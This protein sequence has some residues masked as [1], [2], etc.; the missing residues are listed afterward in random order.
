MDNEVL[1]MTISEFGRRPYENGS[2]GTDHGAASP[3][4]LFGPALQGSGFIGQHPELTEWDADDNLIPTNDFRDVY[5]SVLTNWFCLDPSVID[6]IML[7]GNYQ[8]LD[9]GIE[10][11]VLGTSDFSNPARL[12]HGPV[13]ANG[14]TCIEMNLPN[15]AHTTITL[16]DLMGKQIAVLK[17]ELLF[18]GRHRV[19][20]KQAARTH[21]S[22]GQ[23]IYRISLGG[24]Q[25]SKSLLIR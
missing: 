1:A 25:Y 9:L 14:T 21:L 22:L 16:Y 2:D 23:Y 11:S 4:M 8:T 13:M 24:K 7:G 19:D 10:C 5:H 18:A 15:T 17:N 12:A 6:L 20:V 3:V